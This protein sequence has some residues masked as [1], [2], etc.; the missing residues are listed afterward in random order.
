MPTIKQGLFGKLKT[1]SLMKR[2]GSD[3]VLK[4]R[5]CLQAA[6]LRSC[7]FVANGYALIRNVS[8]AFL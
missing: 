4:R 6:S 1:P 2:R 3:D 8:G 7:P 5:N